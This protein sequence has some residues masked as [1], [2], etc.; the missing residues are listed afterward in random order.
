MT[1]L[2]SFISKSF[3]ICQFRFENEEKLLE[4]EV[5]PGMHDGQ[6]YPFVAEGE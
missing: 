3:L 4:I 1:S 2:Q 5:E 6:E